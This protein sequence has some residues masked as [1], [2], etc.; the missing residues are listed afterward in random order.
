MVR[1]PST[2]T[3]PGGALSSIPFS[4]YLVQNDRNVKFI[5]SSAGV[6]KK[7]MDLY[8]HFSINFMAWCLIMLFLL[9]CP[10]IVNDYNFLVPKKCTY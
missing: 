9:F 7:C 5:T 1:F 10:Y 3:G 4:G 6:K 8:L 2:R